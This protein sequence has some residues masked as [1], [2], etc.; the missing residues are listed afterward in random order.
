MQ[1]TITKIQSFKEQLSNKLILIELRRSS[2]DEV[3]A[4]QHLADIGLIADDLSET[5][6]QYLAFGE[7]G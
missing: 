6:R 3:A 2:K 5:I 7:G 1:N 4:R